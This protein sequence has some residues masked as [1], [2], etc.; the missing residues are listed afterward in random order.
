MD[1]RMGYRI[2]FI[3]FIPFAGSF[4]YHPYF[5]LR[6]RLFP[7][8]IFEKGFLSPHYLLYYLANWSLE[9]MKGYKPSFSR[10]RERERK[11]ER[12]KDS[13]NVCGRPKSAY[14]TNPSTM[15]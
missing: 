10:E 1:V 5:P 14:E 12:K 3:R 13:I 4:L 15:L 6:R 8:Y 7:L 9:V 2:F 11:K